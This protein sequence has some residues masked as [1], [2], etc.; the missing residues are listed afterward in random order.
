MTE[1]PTELENKGRTTPAGC[2][3]RKRTRP[4]RASSEQEPLFVAADSPHHAAA[5]PCPK[6]APSHFHKAHLRSTSMGIEAYCPN[7]HRIKVKDSLAGKKGVCPTCGM[8]FRIPSE[9]GQQ[10]ASPSK[11]VAGAGFE[12]PFPSAADAS[13][14]LARLLSLDPKIVA[15]LPRAVPRDAAALR[16][17]QQPV[18]APS[19]SPAWPAFDQQPE[20]L[21]SESLFDPAPAWNVPAP[22]HLHPAIADREDLVW[23]IAFAGGEPT[24][25]MSAESMQAWLDSQQPTGEEYVWRSDWPE[26]LPF[27]DVFGSR[28]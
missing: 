28:G 3:E 5:N 11:P 4:P 7:G 18:A 2:S 19:D 20:S 6:L 17:P 16:G 14:P 12:T 21:Q 15:T 26:W 13:P 9:T 24:P 23:S 8:K 10:E 27:G 22:P 25:P 1:G